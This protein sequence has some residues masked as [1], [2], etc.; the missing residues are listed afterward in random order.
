MME[1]YLHELVRRKVQSS[2]GE[3]DI[4]TESR[5]IFTVLY[6]IIVT[7]CFGIP[8]LFCFRRGYSEWRRRQ[9]STQGNTEGVSTGNITSDAVFEV[10]EV[11][12]EDV[13]GERRSRQEKKRKRFIESFDEVRLTLTKE[14][15]PK[16]DEKDREEGGSGEPY[17]ISSDEVLYLTIPLSDATKEAGENNSC[18]VPRTRQV[19]N[20]CAICLA[21]YEV[22]DV[23]VLSSNPACGHV[24]HE[25]CI[26]KWLMMLRSES[27][28]PC[29]RNEFVLDAVDDEESE[30]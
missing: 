17:S 6:I 20:C 25:Y 1:P 22:N 27:L 10:G 9:D 19:S 21:S 23:I 3:N 15:F 14:H 4:S 13:V 29:C 18:E 16:K 30:V 2:T 12:R 28:C 7:T 8:V 5:T 26:L 11:A 24:F